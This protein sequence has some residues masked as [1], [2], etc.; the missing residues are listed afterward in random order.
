MPNYW[1][2]TETTWRCALRTEF[3]LPYIQQLRRTLEC[4]RANGE[5]VRPAE[6]EIFEALN[7]TPL[8]RVR[9]VLV[10]QDPYPGA[11]ACGLAFSGTP[12]QARP[13]SLGKVLA[14]VRRDLHIQIPRHE[15]S[16]LP[17]AERGVLLLNRV[18]TVGDNSH[19]HQSLGWE[20]F[21]KQVC[22]I[23]N[24]NQSPVVF[25]LWGGVAKCIEQIVDQPQHR[26]L[27]AAHPNASRIRNNAQ[28]F[29]G[30]RHFSQANSF[31][32]RQRRIEWSLP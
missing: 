15:T 22:R 4:K 3:E 9:V 17:W 20:R 8:D 10:G 27:C 29:R 12:G 2:L 1:T 31:L 16:L 28:R 7:R 5:T 23:V 30:C 19:S 18:L 25:L 6:C 32:G 13:N 14:E 21:T 11:E 26:I 24:G